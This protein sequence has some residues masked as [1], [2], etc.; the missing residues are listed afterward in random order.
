M[1]I[2]FLRMIVNPWVGDC[3]HELLGPAAPFAH[4]HSQPQILIN[5]L[6]AGL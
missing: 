4:A 3:L 6:E 5:F 2:N 1:L